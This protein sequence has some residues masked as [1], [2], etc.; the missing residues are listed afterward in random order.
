MILG[1]LGQSYHPLT[2]TL[3]GRVAIQQ[4]QSDGFIDNKYLNKE[5]TNNR[6]ELTVRGKLRWLATDNISFDLSLFYA[7]IDNGY[8]A[9]SLD[10]NRNT[11]SD[12]PGEDCQERAVSIKAVWEMQ[13]GVTLETVLAYQDS[14]LKYGYDE[15]WALSA[16]IPGN[17]IRWITMCATVIS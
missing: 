9:F 8:D 5:D 3:L 15:D 2:E 13:A 17:I 14:D 6:D 16:F 4:Y 10:N 7:D 12:E 1:V 11:L